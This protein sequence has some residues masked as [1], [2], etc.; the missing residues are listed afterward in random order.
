V[1]ATYRVPLTLTHL[2]CNIQQG[3]RD[4]IDRLGLSGL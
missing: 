1:D 2:L 3:R 4:L